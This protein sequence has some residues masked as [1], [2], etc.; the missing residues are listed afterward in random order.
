MRLTTITI[1]TQ[2]KKILEKLKGDLSWDEFLRNL[3]REYERMI[4]TKLAREYLRRRP[5]SNE[6]AETILRFVEEGRREWSSERN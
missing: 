4:R 5:M 3:A 6:E 1:S 2:T